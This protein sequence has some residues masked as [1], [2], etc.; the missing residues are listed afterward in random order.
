MPPS[1]PAKNMRLAVNVRIEGMEALNGVADNMD[2]AIGAFLRSAGARFA[3]SL[4]AATPRRTGRMASMWRP[5]VDASARTLTMVNAHPGAKAVDR[6][7][8]IKP[9]R[10]DVLHF[11]A[12]GSD[13]YTS[14]PVRIKARQFS[15][16]GLR[17]RGR[18]MQEEFAKAMDHAARGGMV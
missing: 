5:E 9:K 15:K 16:K 1:K 4:A 6:G 3:M 10:R 18:I 11:T 7:A 12:G 8:Y 2:A 14:R 17:G 13:I